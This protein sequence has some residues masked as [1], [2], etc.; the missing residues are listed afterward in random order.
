MIAIEGDNEL[1]YN[2]LQINQLKVT[3][4]GI[5]IDY[6]VEEIKGDAYLQQGKKPLARTAYQAALDAAGETANPALQMK[7]DDLAEAVILN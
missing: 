5:I 2:S 7:L 6:T 3:M 1:H 4:N